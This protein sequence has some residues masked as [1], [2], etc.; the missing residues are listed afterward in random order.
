ME[1]DF[2][3]CLQEQINRLHDHENVKSNIPPKTGVQKMHLSESEITEMFVNVGSILHKD[4]L[5][6]KS[7]EQRNGFYRKSCLREKEE[8]EDRSAQTFHLNRKSTAT[9]TNRIDT[10][11]IGTT[12]NPSTTFDFND[13]RGC[14]H[15]DGIDNIEFLTKAM[16]MTEGGLLDVRVGSKVPRSRI[17]P[18]SIP[19]NSIVIRKEKESFFNSNKVK[20]RLDVL[21]H[22][23]Q[24]NI[25]SQKQLRYR[26]ATK[27]NRN[28]EGGKQ[29]IELLFNMTCDV[30]SKMRVTC[31]CW[32]KRNSDLLAVGY[33]NNSFEDDEVGYVLLW[34]TRM[35]SYPEKIFKTSSPVNA[36]DFSREKPS[37]FAAG[38][39]SGSIQLFDIA[40]EQ[41]IFDS[42]FTPN[43]HMSTITEIQWVPD[44]HQGKNERLVTISIDG[45]RAQKVDRE[46]GVLYY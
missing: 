1:K 33:G 13:K 38:L 16:I 28:G 29:K 12:Y 21:E 36:I 31:L 35:P 32:H 23:L 34:S 9:N 2:P 7:V 42:T 25:Y 22:A 19:F 20:K 4:S 15:N 6:I 14:K 30:V 43:R 24:Q 27:S 40:H 37:L 10:A 17:I 46:R 26:E 45:K 8:F 11:E 18:K 3:D 5:E 39:H 44:S 41:E